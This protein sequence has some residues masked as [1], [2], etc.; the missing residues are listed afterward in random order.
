MSL[1]NSKNLAVATAVAAVRLPQ[2]ATSVQNLCLVGVPTHNTRLS[3][4]AP[5]AK[6]DTHRAAQARYQAQCRVAMSF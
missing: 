5:A 1:L 6:R 3:A 4:P 2:A